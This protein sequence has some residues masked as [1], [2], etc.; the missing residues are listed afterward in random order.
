MAGTSSFPTLAC[1][2]C[3]ERRNLK[4]KTFSYG[5]L[6]IEITNRNNNRKNSTQVVDKI[7]TNRIYIYFKI[8]TLSFSN[9]S[10]STWRAH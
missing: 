7:N 1:T 5:Y 10:V 9:R 4:K 6:Q 8:E 3:P 2:A